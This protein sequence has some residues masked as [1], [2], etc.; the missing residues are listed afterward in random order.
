MNVES[1][2]YR[3]I[4]S[5]LQGKNGVERDERFVYRMRVIYCFYG[6]IA[7]RFPDGAIERWLGIDDT[8]LASLFEYVDCS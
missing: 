7:T 6:I 5:N 8:V 3:E 1:N 2:T 4:V